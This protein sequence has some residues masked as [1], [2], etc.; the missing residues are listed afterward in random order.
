MSAIFFDARWLRPGMTGVGH[1][2]FR[3]LEALAARR[4]DLGLLLPAGSPFRSHFPELRLFEA[5]TDLPDHPR[6]EFYEQISLPRLCRRHG[7]RTLVSFEARVPLFHPGLRT[8]CFV[9]DL[10]HV[11][12]KG[13]H[14]PRYSAYLNFT[15]GVLARSADKVFTISETVRTDLAAHMRRDAARLG[16]VYPADSGLAR[17]APVAVPL[18]AGSQGLLLSVGMTNR[19]K[20]LP[21]LL[22]AFSAFRASHPGYQLALTGDREWIG[23][24]LTQGPSQ[25]VLNLG[26]VAEGQLRW[27]YENA[28]L[29]V[30]PSLD[31][32]FGI[33]LVDASVFGCPIACSDIP[34]FREVAAEAAHYFDPRSP[35]SMAA[36]LGMAL[37]APKDSRPV[38]AR[39]NWDKSAAAFLR[40]LGEA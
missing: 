34:V 5:P 24:E 31:E 9:Y 25:D 23:R 18:P 17:Y 1:F 21:T 40:G 12:V 11:K 26:F 36:C 13:S 19:R 10:A 33:P 38:A 4:K 3:L 30:F 15:L 37:A 20:N 28:K 22:A 29:L 2:A 8:A 27:L 16:V 35:G 39:F 6:T 32:G 7:Y 14:G